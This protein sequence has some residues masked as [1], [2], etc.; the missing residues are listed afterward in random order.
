MPFQVKFARAFEVSLSLVF[1]DLTLLIV[2]AM[3]FDGVIADCCARLDFK[4]LFELVF[5]GSFLF[6]LL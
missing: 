1:D 3:H 5:E 4:G 6:S 2:A